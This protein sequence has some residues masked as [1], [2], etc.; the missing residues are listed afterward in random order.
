[1]LNQQYYAFACENNEEFHNP[2]A[3]DPLQQEQEIQMEM[4]KEIQIYPIHYQIIS[5]K[6]QLH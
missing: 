2:H 1:M 5:Y 3:I 6:I 4:N